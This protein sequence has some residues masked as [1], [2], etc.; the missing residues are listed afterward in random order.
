[1]PVSSPLRF[2]RTARFVAVNRPVFKV[3]GRE[4][5]DGNFSRTKTKR[6][7]PL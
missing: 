1:V 4:G 2:L 3:Q 5:D 7:H 6:R